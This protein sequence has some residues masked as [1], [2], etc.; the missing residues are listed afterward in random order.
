MSKKNAWPS[1]RAPS[2]RGADSTGRAAAGRVGQ[3]RDPRPLAGCP[4]APR[5]RA[6]QHCP[7]LAAPGQAPAAAGQAGFGVAIIDGASVKK[8]TMGCCQFVG[9]RRRS[10]QQTSRQHESSSARASRGS[11]RARQPRAMPTTCRTNRQLVRLM[12]SLAASP[13]APPLARCSLL[14]AGML[15][16]VR[17]LTTLFDAARA[18][19][20]GGVSSADHGAGP[21]PGAGAA[22]E[23]QPDDRPRRQRRHPHH[24]SARLAAARAA[25]R[26]RGGLFEIE[27]IGSIN[28]TKVRDVALEH[29]ERVAV[30]PGE[31]VTIGSTILMVQETRASAR[32]RRVWP[33]T[34][35]EARIEEECARAAETRTPFAIIRL[36]VEGNQPAAHGRRHDRARAAHVRHAGAL[37]PER[38]R[39]L[40]ARDVARSGLGDQQE[41]DRPPARAEHRRPHRHRL[42]SARRADARGAGG[43]LERAPARPRDAAAGRRRRRRGSAHAAGLRA[44][45]AAPRG[46]RS[47]CSSSA[48]PAS[49]RT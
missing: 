46:A 22:Q 3:R 42:P 24:R 45:A 9:Q 33:H 38:L 4:V 27:D 36:A 10:A 7:P 13:R 32:N 12:R 39:D 26:R 29:G 19:A 20:A 2:C 8:R 28:R 15:E 35:F 48:R 11:D 44:G 43:A 49:A 18:A 40:P 37:R 34:H 14:T 25:A 31:A 6:E 23:R 21:V 5:G 30:L 16:S 41:P 1:A 47:A 17:S